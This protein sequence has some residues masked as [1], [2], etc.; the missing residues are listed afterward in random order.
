[1]HKHMKK[2]NA[3]QLVMPNTG[4]MQLLRQ[5][6]GTILL[7]PMYFA[8]ECSGPHIQFVEVTVDDNGVPAPDTK[9]TVVGAVSIRIK[10]DGKVTLKKCDSFDT[11]GDE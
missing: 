9:P 3:I 8:G 11:K 5:E 4:D 7:T 6:G 2:I 10:N 1:M